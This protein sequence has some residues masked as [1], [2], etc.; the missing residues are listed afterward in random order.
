MSTGASFDLKRWKDYIDWKLFILLLLFLNVKLAVKIP[1]IVLVYCLQPNFRFGFRLRDPRL[2]LFYPLIIAVALLGMLVNGDFREPNYLLVFLTGAGFWL[3]CLLAIHQ[4]KLSVDQQ[5]TEKIHHTL[6]VFFVLNAAVSAGN[7]LSIIWEIRDLN[8][9]TY[10]AQYQ[11]YFINTGDYIRGLTFDTSTTNAVI[12]AMGII[13]FFTRK[14]YLWLLVCMAA[15]LLTASNIL[16]IAVVLILGFLFC[17]RSNRDQKS[18]V[19]V[20][21]IFLLVFMSK[22]SPQNLEYVGNNIE[23]M[24]GMEKPAAPHREVSLLEMAQQ[25]DSVLTAEQRRQKTA[26]LYMDSLTRVWHAELKRLHPN[27]Q[28]AEEQLL[29]PEPPIHSASYQSIKDPV[30]LED[31]IVQFI[32]RYSPVLPYATGA[33]PT[34]HL[35]GKAIGLLQ[36]ASFIVQHPGHILLGN[37]MGNFSSKLAFRVT[38]LGFAGGFPQKHTYINTDFMHNHLDLY[39]NF[40]SRQSGYHSLVNTPFSV[41]DQLLSEYGVLGLLLFL[42]AYLGFFWRHYRRLT[43]GIPLLLLMMGIFFID[44][45]FEQLSVLVLFELLLLLN[46]KETATVQGGPAYD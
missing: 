22:V 44:Y 35:P 23:K 4:V 24:A 8:P 25:P 33:I 31:P 28:P 2:P 16:N 42:A 9:Y 21:L 12:N 5:S 26:I 20:C 29:L 10:Q 32:H 7:L 1:A 30:S 18:F 43:Y 6:L 15:L 19:V 39:L 37:G 41:Y 46:I 40:F 34:P 14:Q 13:Y 17:F 27:V 36:T 3:L 11:K 38:G 45:W